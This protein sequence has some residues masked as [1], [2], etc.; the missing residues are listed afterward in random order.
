M[1]KEKLS[2]HFKSE[3]QKIDQTANPLY[4][5]KRTALPAVTNES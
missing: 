5:I 4:Q 2:I 3:L 1:N